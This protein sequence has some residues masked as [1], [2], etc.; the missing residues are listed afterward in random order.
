MNDFNFDSYFAALLTP[1]E[2][3]TSD[4]LTNVDKLP[5]IHTLGATHAGLT[6]LFSSG[7]N[8]SLAET[9][10]LKTI[11][12]EELSGELSSSSTNLEDNF[13]EES[14]WIR[15]DRIPESLLSEGESNNVAESPISNS[16]SEEDAV[17]SPIPVIASVKQTI[18]KVNKEPK[19]SP[20]KKSPKE[21]P[22]KNKAVQ[23]K[24][25]Q[26]KSSKK[27]TKG[28][29]VQ[30]KVTKEK[31]SLKRSRSS[32]EPASSEAASKKRRTNYCFDIHRIYCP[33]TK[34][35]KYYCNVTLQGKLQET[36][37]LIKGKRGK[38]AYTFYDHRK[39]S[40]ERRYWPSQSCGPVIEDGC[41][42]KNCSETTIDDGC[43][44]KP[45]SETAPNKIPSVPEIKRE[46]STSKGTATTEDNC[47]L[48][49]EDVFLDM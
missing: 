48:V 29:Q 35:E 26:K 3:P 44:C 18:T 16:I 45:S 9:A 10:T 7:N 33:Q 8:D 15:D 1:I 24:G 27:E 12:N 6:N 28:K 41:A 5:P 30:E 46:I 36:V 31:K 21:T 11:K 39:R 42:C 34:K 32:E 43:S 17:A 49:L 13:L 2:L 23:K 22:E 20:K 37:D 40:K 4:N 14:S 19:K 38:Y 25:S 47:V